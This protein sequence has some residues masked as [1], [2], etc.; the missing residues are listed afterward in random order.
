[1]SVLDRL[2]RALLLAIVIV[3][4]A[5]CTSNPS[6]D[7][8]ASQVIVAT[9]YDPKVNFGSFST[10]AVTQT[11]PIVSALSDAG[12]IIAE[13]GSGSNVDP[14]VADPIFAEI[15][16]LLTA[17]GYRSVDRTQHPDL[18]VNVVLL[19]QQKSQTVSTG[20]WWGVGAG[21]PTY[22]APTPGA[23]YAPW[24][25]S[26]VSWSSGTLIIEIYNLRDSGLYNSPLVAGDAGAVTLAGAQLEDTWGAFIHGVLGP[27]N[28]TLTAPPIAQIQQAFAQSPYLTR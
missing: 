21:A 27:T 28:A 26:T 1:M 7:E 4:A 15:T 2:V 23:I 25:Y 9:K 8:I 19:E 6:G 11:I 12:P 17:R 13:A 3:A 10:F 20:A 18:G 5:T 24:S 22:W 16:A 14:A